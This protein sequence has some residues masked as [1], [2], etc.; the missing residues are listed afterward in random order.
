MSFEVNGASKNSY[1]RLVLDLH[2]ESGE[3]LG[4]DPFSILV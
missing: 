1:L 4:V 3:E 2:L